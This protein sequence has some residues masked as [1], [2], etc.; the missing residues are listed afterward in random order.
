MSI[1]V[2]LPNPDAGAT[3]P[4]ATAAVSGDAWRYPD[5][6][7]ESSVALHRSEANAAGALWAGSCRDRK[8]VV[9]GKSVSVSVDLGGRRS[10]QK[11]R[12]IQVRNK[13]ITTMKTK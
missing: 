2:S 10:I 13:H 1:C 4:R 9:G 8:R 11:K 3:G 6:A 12:K 7:S 5:T